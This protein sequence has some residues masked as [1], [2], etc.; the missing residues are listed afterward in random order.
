MTACKGSFRFG[1][2]ARICLI[3]GFVFVCFMSLSSFFLMHTYDNTL[4]NVKLSRAEERA[5]IIGGGIHS[6]I[7]SATDTLYLV[8]QFFSLLDQKQAVRSEE[9]KSVFSVYLSE[10]VN[11]FLFF[12]SVSVYDENG[13]L[14]Y[15]SAQKFQRGLSL[16]ET[17]LCGNV[18]YDRKIVFGFPFVSKQYGKT[19]MPLALGL[20]YEEKKYIICGLLNLEKLTDEYLRHDGDIAQ[21]SF[22]VSRNGVVL[23]CSDPQYKGTRILQSQLDFLHADDFGSRRYKHEEDE[24]YYGFYNIP[25]TD[26]YYVVYLYEDKYDRWR[27][28]LYA[29]SVLLR[30]AAVLFGIFGVLLL[31][32]PI[33]RDIRSLTVFIKNISAKNFEKKHVDKKILQRGDEIG[34]F[35]RSLEAM[36]QNMME[37]LAKANEHSHIKNKFIEKMSYEIRTPVD[38]INAVCTLALQTCSDPLQK[39]YLTQI[40]TISQNVLKL[41]EN[42]LNFSQRDIENCLVNDEL[43]NLYEML[44]SVKS[45]LKIKSGEKGL[46][47]N[48]SIDANVPKYIRSNKENLRRI[49]LNL[50]N[51]AIKFTDKGYVHA[52]ISCEP[53]KNGQALIFDIVDSGMGMDEEK[54]K[55]VFNFDSQKDSL[56]GFTK[57]NARGLLIVKTLVDVMKGEI[58]I[59]SAI[60]KGTSVKVIVPVERAALDE[61][62]GKFALSDSD[63]NFLTVLVAEG[64]KAVADKLQNLLE[65]ANCR[66]LV[67]AGGKD[68]VKIAMESQLDMA[69]IDMEMQIVAG[70]DTVR[71]ILNI[72]EQRNLFIV[73]MSKNFTYESK[74]SAYE[75]GVADCLDKEF[76][77]ESFYSQLKVWAGRIKE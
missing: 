54:L 22:I 39:N 3:I 4:D 45:L 55:N 52:E 65:Q 59:Q 14:L 32:W 13:R 28:A 76:S 18:A 66:V 70:F 24:W 29:R 25:Q 23:N 71:E 40:E 77:A 37:I 6:Q 61:K 62:N 5:V 41:I 34:D 63:R 44:Y 7:R 20:V 1:L 60:K 17:S 47:Y 21:R 73:G 35:A 11:A 58:Q 72:P 19:E 12:D 69:F 15:G 48:V 50:I 8:A 64:D 10:V 27:S 49:L 46:H 9:L 30:S 53:Y 75:A 31:L 38:N 74:T 33:A 51:N 67:A 36:V 42:I 68:A 57:F 56:P 26:F 43:F 2:K 16:A